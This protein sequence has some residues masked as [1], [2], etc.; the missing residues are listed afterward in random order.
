MYKVFRYLWNGG[1]IKEVP[2][3]KDDIKTY[4]DVHYSLVYNDS[5]FKKDLAELRNEHE[6]DIATATDTAKKQSYFEPL[7]DKWRIATDKVY[8]AYEGGEIDGSVP[9]DLGEQSYTVD[10]DAF[11]TQRIV[12]IEIDL[13]NIKKSDYDALWKMSALAKAS[14]GIPPSRNRHPEDPK[15]IYAVFKARLEGD[16]FRTIFRQ[17]QDGTLIGYKDVPSNQFKSEDSL[18]R[19]YR[20]Y[21]P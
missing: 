9:R 4:S 7:A 14:R 21:I 5:E 12:T 1:E 20:K 17:Y 11:K 6:S 15:L 10:V 3:N 8:S 16:I 13:V 2:L 19:Y 18:E